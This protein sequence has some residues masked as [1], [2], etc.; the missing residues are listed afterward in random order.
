MRKL[1]LARLRLERR[2]QELDSL[3]AVGKAV[4][5]SLELNEILEAIFQQI[6]RLMPADNFYI[7][8]YDRQTDQVSFPLVVEEGQRIQGPSRKSGSGL[9]EYILRTNTPILATGNTNTIRRTLGLSPSNKPAASWVGVPIVAGEESLGVI[10]L[11]SY[12]SAGVYDHAHQAVLAAIAAQAAIA[13]TNAHLHARTDEALGWRLQQ[14]TSILEATHDGILLLNLGGH[15]ITA[16][17]ALAALLDV[18]LNELLHASVHTGLGPDQLSIAERLGYTEGEFQTEMARILQGAQPG[19]KQMVKI[20][21]VPGRYV[22]RSLQPVQGA[23]GIDGLL[24]VLRDMSEEYK[25]EQ[26][27]EDLIQMIIHD[28]R[29]PLTIIQSGSEAVRSSIESD[30]T[31]NAAHILEMIGK[32]TSRMLNLIN[33]MLDIRKLESADLVLDLHPIQLPSLFHDLIE[34]YSPTLQ[35]AKIQINLDFPQDLPPING[36]S[37]HVARIFSNLLDNSIKFTPDGGQIE[38]GAGYEPDSEPPRLIISIKDNGVGIASE[39]LPQVFE[40]LKTSSSNNGR[41]KGSGLGLYYCKLAVEAHQGQ[42]WAASEENQG[43]TFWVA[44][45]AAC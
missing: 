21:L 42:I 11:Q 36:D 5:S 28:L 1:A 17:P 3:Q 6:R 4:S 20:P 19:Q 30:Q 44:L 45:P 8:L 14:L 12:K 2:I 9:T 23:D 15:V 10:A 35:R 37:E 16:N 34:Q 33:Q 41:R 26:L 27:R 29:A 40:K 24:I 18:P 43:S 31:E 39:M 7:A 22:E 13:L 38:V 25:L 32:N